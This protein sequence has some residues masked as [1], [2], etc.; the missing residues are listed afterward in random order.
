MRVGVLAIGHKHTGARKFAQLGVAREHPTLGLTH[1]GMGSPQDS[2]VT[3]A[4]FEC[5]KRLRLIHILDYDVFFGKPEDA[6][7]HAERIVGGRHRG[8]QERLALHGFG[9]AEDVRIILVPTLH[10]GDGAVGADKDTVDERFLVGVADHIRIVTERAHHGGHGPHTGDSPFTGGKRIQNRHAG[11]E[12]QD[13]NVQP[14]FLIPAFFLGIPDEEGFMFVHPRGTDLGQGSGKGRRAYGKAEQQGDTATEKLSEAHT[15][16]LM[17]KILVNAT[18][19]VSSEEVTSFVSVP[20]PD[21]SV[22]TWHS[23]HKEPL[24]GF[25]IILFQYVV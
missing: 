10:L 22:A 5:T 4:V 14:D 2:T 1:V 11:A 21:L 3:N 17:T 8:G 25:L 13:F 15:F 19:A 6:Q 23:G 12:I 20:G 16:L 9:A 7:P 24:L 18:R